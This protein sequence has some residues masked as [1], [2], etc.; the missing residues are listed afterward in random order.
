PLGLG[1][2][3]LEVIGHGAE[4][5]LPPLEVPEGLLDKF[6]E[7]DVDQGPDLV[8]SLG[9]PFG[10]ELVEELLEAEGE[11]PDVV[12]F[13]EDEVDHL[14]QRLTEA[15]GIGCLEADGKVAGP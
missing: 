8:L 11:Q 7:A 9:E 12:P 10:A 5:R 13:S 15:A 1:D 4:L 14:R 2:H 3:A 6:P